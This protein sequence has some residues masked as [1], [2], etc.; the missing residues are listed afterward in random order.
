VIAVL[1]FGREILVPFALAVLLSF[2]LAPGVRWLR[3]WY[4]GRV[5]SVIVMV[6][7]AFLVIFSLGAVIATQVAMLGEQLPQYEWVIRSKIRSLQDAFAGSSL[8]DRASH[9]LQNLSEELAR[10]ERRVEPLAP[11]GSAEEP[12]PEPLPVEINPNPGRFKSS[13]ALSNHCCS[14]RQRPGSSSSSSF[15]SCCNDRICATG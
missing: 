1:Y 7:L 13:K 12:K 2:V 14:P 10:P 9:M 6:V 4:V 5:T 11:L 8:V 3:R 15:S